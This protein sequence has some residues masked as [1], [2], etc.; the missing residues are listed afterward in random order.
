MVEVL[1]NGGSV[2]WWDE[3]F[4]FGERKAE[5]L[6]ACMDILRKFWLSTDDE[7]R[8]F[9]PRLVENQ[10]AGLR[11][12]VSVEMH[13][14]FERSTGWTI[15]RPW[16]HL[17]ALSPHNEHIGLGAMKCRA[18]C[19]VENDLSKWLL[20]QQ[21]ERSEDL[22][23]ELRR[24]LHHIAVEAPSREVS[25][26][27]EPE[28][29]TNL[30]SKATP[31]GNLSKEDLFRRIDELEK[32]LERGV[33]GPPPP[34]LT[35]LTPESQTLSMIFSTGPY[36]LGAD[37]GSLQGLVELTS[38]E[39]LAMPKEFPGERIFKGP[40]VDFLGHRWEIWIGSIEGCVYKILAETTPND[41]MEALTMLTYCEATLGK[42]TKQKQHVR[43][44]WTTTIWSMEE[45]N[46]VLGY[47]GPG[48]CRVNLALTSA[49][50]VRSKSVAKKKGFLSRIWG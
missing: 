7:R 45:G 17:Q 34:D 32:K 14:D 5:M 15:D 11:I 24:E 46:V 44:N 40:P 10:K 2:G 23:K 27:A 39:Y 37:I 30:E 1:K 42:P 12:Q 41:P 6:I 4:Q 19:A 8:A 38:L 21:P 25:T 29:P 48:P 33:A 28:N 47:G 36:T 3:H 26:P 16:L 43:I 35:R 9:P 22:V 13:P 20:K 18:I 31:N 50:V 49:I